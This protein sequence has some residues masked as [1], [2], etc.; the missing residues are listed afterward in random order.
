M[1]LLLQIWGGSFYLANKVLLACAEGR[2]APVQRR[3]K[4][5]GWSIFLLGVPA[6]VIILIGQHDWI[7]AA[8]EAGGIPA[9]LLGLYN[10]IQH[11]QQA[12]RRLNRLVSLCIYV[13]LAIGLTLSLIHHGGLTSLTQVLESG[14]MVGFLLGSYILA[15]GNPLGWLFFMLMNLSM[16]ALMY[17]QAHPILMV[18]QL[19]SLC[20]V[21]Y[22]FIQASRLKS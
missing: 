7:A 13:A 12:S 8:I 11:P 14:V 22:G 21:L 20:F 3:L 6:W 10:T 5:A 18:Q 17:L 16:A 1:D 19:I 15:Q 9:M 2:S 4:I